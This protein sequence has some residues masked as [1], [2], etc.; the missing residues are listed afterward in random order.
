MQLNRDLGPRHG[1]ARWRDTIGVLA[2]SEDWIAQI[3]TGLFGHEALGWS[4]TAGWPENVRV[5]EG[6]NVFDPG[7]PFGRLPLTDLSVPDGL[8]ARVTQV[9][10]HGVKTLSVILG[11]TAEFRGV[12]P[13]ARVRP[14]RAANGPVFVGE[15]KTGA[16]GDALDHALASPRPPRVVTISMGNPGGSPAHLLNAFGVKSTPG[17]QKRTVDAINRAYEMGVIVVCAGGQIHNT[18]AYPARF[19]RTIAVGG[20]TEPASRFTCAQYPDGGYG[21]NGLIDVWAQAANLNRASGVRA[22]DGKPLRFFADTNDPRNTERKPV[23][24]SYA[25]PQVAAAAALWVAR[26]R[27]MLE[28]FDARWKIV[29]AFRKA[30][31]AS[32]DDV[33]VLRRINAGPNDRIRVR[34]LN[35]EA[36]LGVEPDLDAA[37]ARI[38]RHSAHSSWL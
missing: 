8:V 20:L 15:A 1:D 21:E 30:L 11:A 3:D 5:D 18:V 19:K 22:P 4:E 10:D 37:Y 26:H 33:R 29:E 24:T 16:I 12:A 27:A 25:A 13:G 38:P 2:A 6:L 32:A 9:P 7:G 36:L 35:I 31:R 23:G 17:M 28:R 34:A 14:Y